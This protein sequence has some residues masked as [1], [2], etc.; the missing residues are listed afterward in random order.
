VASHTP[1]E[2]YRPYILDG[3]AVGEGNNIVLRHVDTCVP[4]APNFGSL[5]EYK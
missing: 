3:E 4:K 5:H 2:E 1:K